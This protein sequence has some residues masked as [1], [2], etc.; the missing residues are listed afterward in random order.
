[1]SSGLLS[2]NIK[3]MIQQTIILPVVVVVVVIV[4][5]VVVRN[6]GRSH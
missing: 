6:M 2:E 5:V 4:V 1:M 3:I